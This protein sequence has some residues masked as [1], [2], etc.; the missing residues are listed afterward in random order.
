MRNRTNPRHG[1]DHNDRHF[2][3]AERGG[4]WDHD[5]GHDHGRTHEGRMRGGRGIG[6]RR[7]RVFDHG[8]LRLVMLQLIAERPR[9]GYE[10]IK[11]IEELVGGAYSPSPGVVYPTLTML[12]ELGHV[13]VAEHDGKKLHALTDQGRASLEDNRQA[14][15]ALQARM[16]QIAGT[17]AEEPPPA[18]IRATE[19]LKLALRL[20][21]Q[22]G[23]MTAEQARTIAAA[24]D[25]AATAV[26]Q[27]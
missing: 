25:A 11:A 4:G 27:A 8:D 6:G 3:R 7:G 17:R 5:H 19:N 22:H 1:H 20:K 15:E 18:V 12:E 21:L 16:A 9:H 26:E 13:T 2:A 24:L 14:V 10:I 23:G